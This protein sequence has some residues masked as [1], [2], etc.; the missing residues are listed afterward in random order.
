MLAAVDE[1]V[2]QVIQTLDTQGLIEQH[3]RRVHCLTTATTWDSTGS[4]RARAAPYEE[5][6]HVPFMVRGPGVPAGTQRAEVGT[7]IDLTPTFADIAARR[8]AFPATVAPCC[9]CGIPLVS[10]RGAPGC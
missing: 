3:L 5:D 1:L 8:W 2:A 9:R 10:C 4:C 7:I 6:T